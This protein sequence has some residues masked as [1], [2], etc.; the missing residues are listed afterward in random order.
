MR[1]LYQHFPRCPDISLHH[2][3]LQSKCLNSCLRA[4]TTFTSITI[5]QRI[6]YLNASNRLL[7]LPPG[8]DLPRPVRV[9]HDLYD[10]PLG[11]KS[12]L[13]L[14]ELPT[15]LAEFLLSSSLEHLPTSP[16]EPSP[17]TSLAPLHH[18]VSA[19]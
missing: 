13:L 3:L 18:R 17:L 4:L 14:A 15:L 8:L 10:G 2:V 9:V 19:D 7:L 16:N 1:Y 12:D 6:L 5:L 11:F